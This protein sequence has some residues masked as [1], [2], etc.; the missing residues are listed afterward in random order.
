MEVMIQTYR[1]DPGL[2][3]TASQAVFAHKEMTSITGMAI[4]PFDFHFRQRPYLCPDTP[5]DIVLEI[6]IAKIQV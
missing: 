5:T 2:G 4:L 3:F 1:P 6:N